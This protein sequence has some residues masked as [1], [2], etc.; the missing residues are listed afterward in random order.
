M[1]LLS[2]MHGSTVEN[3]MVVRLPKHFFP[4]VEERQDASIVAGVT[5]VVQ[6]LAEQWQHVLL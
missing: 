1:A 4:S 3:E 2:S 6:H 5:A